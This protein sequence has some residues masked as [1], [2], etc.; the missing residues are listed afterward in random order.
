LVA[1]RASD[2]SQLV[3]G[4]NRSAIVDT[5]AV[6]AAA[7]ARPHLIAVTYIGLGWGLPWYR[8]SDPKGASVYPGVSPSGR[9]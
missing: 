5:A 2:V 4:R 6:A 1:A 7:I 3:A 8:D 9:M